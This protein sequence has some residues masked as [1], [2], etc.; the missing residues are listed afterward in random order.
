MLMNSFKLTKENAEALA[1]Q[2]ATPIEV[3]SLK[4]IEANY[5]FLQEHIPRLKIYY[6]IKANPATCILEKLKDLGSNFDV[7]SDGEIEKLQRLKI[8]G[9]RM[10]YANPVK[11]VKGLLAAKKAGI[12]RMTFDSKTEVNKIAE[13]I[14]NAEVL[15]RVRIDNSDAVVD[16]NIKFGAERQY[17][18]DLLK[19]AQTKGLKAVGICFHVGSQSISAQNYLRAFTIVREL[20]DEARQNGID[21]K[22]IDI[23]GGLPAPALHT[24][25]DVEKI[26]NDINRCIEENFIDV[27]VWA[28]PGRYI[29]ASAV[30]ILTAVI[31]SQKRGGQDW[32]YLDDGIYGCFSGKF[33]DHWDYD[34]H[35]FKNGEKTVAT[36]AGPSCD[37]LDIIKNKMLCPKLDIGDL[38]V[39]VNAGAYSRVSATTFN[40]F[41]LPQTV[42]W[43]E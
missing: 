13:Y 11:T 41:S 4:H 26:M 25:I 6:A 12:R 8:S 24:D 7:A 5:E 21:I 14:P 2:Y 17:I 1:N 15:V 19:Y 32:Y 31:G 43:K 16:L 35:A 42:V 36:L 30:N 27:E 18:V 39:A 3:I 22:Y 29:C 20:I 37:S 34:I 10:I 38:L 40:G 28:E 9:E 23:G 33:F